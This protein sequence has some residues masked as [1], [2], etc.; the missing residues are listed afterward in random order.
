MPKKF[1]DIKFKMPNDVPEAMNGRARLK[2]IEIT[3]FN[4]GNT[5]TIPMVL[6]IP[7]RQ[8]KT[9]PGF[10]VSAVIWEGRAK[11][12]LRNLCMKR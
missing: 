2:E 1:D 4:K 10:P 6:F 8:K 7:N 12:N 3:V 11:R 5:L 9:C